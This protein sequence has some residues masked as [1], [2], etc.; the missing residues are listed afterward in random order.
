MRLAKRTASR[1]KIP[2]LFENLFPPKR[3]SFEDI[4]DGTRFVIESDGVHPPKMAGKDEDLPYRLRWY[5]AQD[6]ARQS[7]QSA[8]T[9]V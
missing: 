8:S 7:Y 9:D 5:D 6:H 3:T 4:D 1:E 2:K